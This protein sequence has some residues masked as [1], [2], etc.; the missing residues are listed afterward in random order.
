MRWEGPQWSALETPRTGCSW[1]S[2]LLLGSG[3]PGASFHRLL[4]HWTEKGREMEIV[5]RDFSVPLWAVEEGRTSLHRGMPPGSSVPALWEK[6]VSCAS[7]FL[8]DAR[9]VVWSVRKVLRGKVASPHPCSQDW[10]TART[11]RSA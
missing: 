5:E 6:C 2:S 9:S 7:T 11:S 3:R 4:S 10:I 8:P 1:R